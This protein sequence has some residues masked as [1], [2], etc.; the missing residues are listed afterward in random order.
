MMLVYP[1]RETVLIS[2]KSK[3]C[4]LIASGDVKPLKSLLQ[5]GT[6][7]MNLAEI[8]EAVNAIKKEDDRNEGD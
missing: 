6:A 3:W 2:I 7:I 8:C 4:E 5:K 1:K